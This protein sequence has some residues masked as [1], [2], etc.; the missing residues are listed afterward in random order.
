MNARTLEKRIAQLRQD[1]DRTGIRLRRYTRDPKLRPPLDPGQPDTGKRP[2]ELADT[3]WPEWIK[4]RGDVAALPEVPTAQQLATLE[5]RGQEIDRQA[6]LIQRDLISN[7]SGEAGAK[8]VFWLVT[9]LAFLVVLY[10]VTHGVHSLDIT[11][12]DP[13]PEWGPMKY[14]EVAF[15]SA[16]GV[17]CNMLYLATAYLARRDFDPA[18][19]SW[20]L[21]TALRAPFLTIILMMIIL[22]FVE[23]YADDKW[24]RNYLLEEGNKFYFIVFM[25]FCLGIA[26]DGTASILRD[27]SSGVVDFVRGAIGKVTA[28]L[29][30][31][32]A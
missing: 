29:G 30:G 16:F 14:G 5:L 7:E 15:W 3:V 12:F 28:R 13:W 23:W 21:S 17:I 24:L 31:G 11:T 6:D 1:V 32:S 27:L 10:L 26:S 25:S 8:T 20:Y 9:A 19:K 18:F 22:E 2:R 4:L